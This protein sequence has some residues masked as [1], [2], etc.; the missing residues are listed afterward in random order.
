GAVPAGR[1]GEMAE[2]TPL[3]QVKGLLLDAASQLGKV[4]VAARRNYVSAL[5]LLKRSSDVFAEASARVHARELA[6]TGDEAEAAEAA[7]DPD[8]Y[9]EEVFVPPESSWQR[10]LGSTRVVGEVL[11]GALGGLEKYNA[12]LAGILTHIDFNRTPGG[13]RLNDET[14]TGLIRTFDRVS[15]RDADLEFPG[16]IGG[17]EQRRH[18]HAGVDRPAD[19]PARGARA[20]PGRLRPVR[21]VRRP[22]HPGAA[23]RRRPLPRQ[24]GASGVGRA[25]GLG[26]PVGQ[27]AAQPSLPRDPGRRRPARRHVARSQ[28][29]CWKGGQAVRPRAVRSRVLRLL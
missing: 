24:I 25:G 9:T 14:L 16:L 19:G 29:P 6:R 23:V 15:L 5:L 11:N 28:A 20:G 13:A 21:G 26:A 17:V 8:E 1:G 18:V 22:A 12:D 2:V 3:H 4:D 27:R 10:L 7:G